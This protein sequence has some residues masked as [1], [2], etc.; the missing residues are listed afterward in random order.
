MLR[1]KRVRARTRTALKS[2]ALFGVVLTAFLCAAGATSAD[3]YLPEP[4]E[5]PFDTSFTPS[6][7]PAGKAAPVSLAFRQTIRRPDGSHPPALQ[8]LQL[9]LDRHF[10]LS[11]KGV[12]RCGPPIQESPV[13]EGVLSRCEDAK[14]GSGT[15][16]VE[17]A[18]PEQQPVRISGRVSIYNMGRWDGSTRFLL[19]AL[20]P[21]P[22]T[23]AITPELG[24]HRES[25]GTYGWKGVLTVPKIADGAGSVTYL[26]V[27]FRKGIFSASCPEGQLL[28]HA[29]SRFVDGDVASG[30]LIHT[31][32]TAAAG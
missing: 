10:G 11:V 9:D 8:E 29:S 12:P 21:A 16:E 3:V 28:A 2:I 5:V 1:E 30:T 17:V 32:K 15:I 25:R 6:R 24:V 27:R 22:V 23:G 26:G 14:V 4:T 31:C 20:I 7:L 19:Y 13:R 18:F